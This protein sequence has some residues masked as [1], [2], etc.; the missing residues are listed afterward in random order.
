[1]TFSRMKAPSGAEVVADTM[2]DGRFRIRV[3]VHGYMTVIDLEQA[4]D[5][6]AGLGALLQDHYYETS[7][8]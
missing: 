4:K 8:R 2:E 1:M 3:G 7:Q 5:L 6:Y